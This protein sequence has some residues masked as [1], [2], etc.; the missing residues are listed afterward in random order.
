MRR[1]YEVYKQVCAS[2][3]SLQYLAYRH[4]VGQTHSE[5]EAKAEA[6]EMTVKLFKFF[7]SYSSYSGKICLNCFEL[8]R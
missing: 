7:N 3:H 5:E 2:C 6:E 1:G 4:L 8:G